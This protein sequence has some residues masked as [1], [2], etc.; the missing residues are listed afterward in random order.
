MENSKIEWTDHTFN[1]WWGCMKVSE[2]CK[3]C[4]A[5]TLDSRWKG[6]HWGPGSSRKPMSEAY[7]KQPSKWDKAAARA[8][9]K[10]KVFCASMADV[11][12]GHPDT[13]PHLSRLFNLIDN[14]PNLIWQLL[15]KRPEHINILSKGHW[16]NGLPENVW[17]GTSVENQD[18][19]KKRVRELLKVNAIIRFLSIEPLLENVN[20][21][22]PLLPTDVITANTCCKNPNRNFGIHWVIVGGESGHNA[23]PLHPD[24]VRNIREDSDRIGAAFFFKQW[25]EWLPV[26]RGRLYREPSIDF[27]DGQQM[28][29]VGKRV[30]GR[31]LD[32]IEYNDFPNY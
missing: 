13:L 29:K 15:T 7:W 10:A 4:Y 3:N 27:T 28:V 31:K 25:G 11:F 19:A 22:F 23:R 21:R 17:I 30:A 6:G 14:T 8:G 20:L 24:W 32:G 26:E 16:P 5:E 1:P 18:T 9:V 2:G 12:E